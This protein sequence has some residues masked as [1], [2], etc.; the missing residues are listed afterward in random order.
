[1]LA[2]GRDDEQRGARVQ[3]VHAL[4]AREGRRR[5]PLP[6]VPQLQR[7]VPGPGGDERRAGVR[8]AGGVGVRV[9][10]VHEAHAA[11]GLRVRVRERVVLPRGRVQQVQFLVGAGGDD[12]GPVLFA[13]L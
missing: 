1:M 2:R 11:D 8:L 6:Q 9:G 13:F 4:G 7:P 3:G 10:D 12:E 5:A